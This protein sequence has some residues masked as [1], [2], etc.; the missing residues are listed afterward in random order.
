MT[1][2]NNAELYFFL[3]FQ[4]LTFAEPAFF[5]SPSDRHNERGEEIGEDGR[6]CGRKDGSGGCERGWQPSGGETDGSKEKNSTH[7]PLNASTGL[8]PSR[9]AAVH[10]S[11]TPLY[12]YSIDSSHCVHP[13]VQYGLHVS[14]TSCFFT[15]YFSSSVAQFKVCVCERV[16]QHPSIVCVLFDI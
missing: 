2:G 16:K 10:H 13:E 11:I 6:S 9:Y 8:S 1:C 7:P 15:F 12:Y 3:L 4:E 5:F 14:H